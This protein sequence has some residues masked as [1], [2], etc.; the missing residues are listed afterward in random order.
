MV[1]KVSNPSLKKAESIKKERRMKSAKGAV[2]PR[3]KAPKKLYEKLIKLDPVLHGDTKIRNLGRYHFA[4]SIRTAPVNVVE[5]IAVGR[6]MPVLFMKGDPPVPVALMGLRRG[7]NMMIDSKGNW[8]MDG[9]VPS[10]LRRYP[11]IIKRTDEGETEVYIDENANNLSK[12]TGE[13]LFVDAEATKT[14]E[15]MAKHAAIYA[16]E[17]ARTYQMCHYAQEKALFREG[18]L[19]IRASA[20]RGIKLKGF[21]SIDPEKLRNLD[22]DSVYHLWE[23]GWAGAVFAHL[24]S[25]GQFQS[26]LEKK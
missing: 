9:Y 7:E 21:I 20:E 16:K 13:P 15:R 17:Q 2:S 22:K 11:F 10:F 4:K 25:L 6:Q 24:D 5:F 18:D 23:M 19:E 3:K 8:R 12:R 26:L 14:T 1:I